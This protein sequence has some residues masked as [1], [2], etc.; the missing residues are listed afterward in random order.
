MVFLLTAVSFVERL[1]PIERDYFLWLNHHR[2][3]FLDTFMYIYS[4]KNTWIPLAIL[5][6][7]VL[8]Y[9]ANWKNAVLFIICGI[10][11]GI[12]CDLVSAELI[13]PFF[14]RLRPTH[15]PD[16]KELVDIVNN[17]RGGQ[18]GF[19]SNHAANG[20]GIAIFAS[21]LFRYRYYTL[22]VY[23]WVLITAYSRIYLGVH[24]IT[25]VIGGFIWG[26]LAGIAVYFLY[27]Y[28]RYKIDD[29]SKKDLMKP[30]LSRRRA[31]VL[32]LGIAVTLVFIVVYALLIPI[33]S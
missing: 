29:V 31:R 1:L 18:F 24:F 6:A 8:L 7:I 28:I 4:D 23:T 21:L 9:K 10:G 22:A 19:I 20:F 25:D 5:L 14:A 32:I 15:H 2:T 3:D 12:L 13:K 27:I 30:M 26:T 33:E 11:I 17:H 16:F